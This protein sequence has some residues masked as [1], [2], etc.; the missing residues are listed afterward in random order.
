[1]HQPAEAP[2]F[3]PLSVVKR[4]SSGVGATTERRESEAGT[5]EQV[6]TGECCAIPG[7]PPG[8]LS[9]QSLMMRDFIEPP[10]ALLVL[11][12]P[13]THETDIPS[14]LGHRLKR[15]NVTV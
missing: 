3:H 11:G 6:P 14:L 15:V 4:G 13:L 10:S 7:W 5:G 8:L 12:K 2:T 9:G 1:M